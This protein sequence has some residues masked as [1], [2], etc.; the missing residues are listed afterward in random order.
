MS[1]MPTHVH[2]IGIGGINMSAIAKLLFR[3]GVKVS[4]SDVVASEQTEE[5]VRKGIP[6]IIGH[7]QAFVPEDAT[8]IIYSSAVPESDPERR[9]ARARG[10]RELTN[11]EFLAQWAQDQRVVLVTGTHGKS[12]TTALAG[13]MLIEGGLDPLVIV[14]SKVP[15][16]TD[17]NVRSGGGSIWLIEG[18]E[19]ARHFL[20]FQPQAILINNIELDHTDIFPTLDHMVGAFRELLHQVRDGGLVVANA[21][22]RNVSTLLGGERTALEARGVKIVTYGYGAH[23]MVRVSDEAIRVGE[24]LFLI[25]DERGQMIR[26]SLHVPGRMNICNATGAAALALALGAGTEPIRRAVNAFTGIWRRFETISDK[27]GVLV[28]SDYGHHPTAIRST[29]EAAR[30]FYPGRRI[31]LCFQPHQHNRTRQ[32]FLDFVPSFDLADALVLVEIYDVPGRKTHED[33]QVSSKDLCDA[34]RHHDAD[35][36]SQRPLEYAATVHEASP[37]IERWKRKGDIVIVMGAGDVYK[38]AEKL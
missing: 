22:D 18:D 13:L 16:F 23:A 26:G 27:D 1:E 25:K 8:L 14:G 31:V 15:A 20:A 33:E 21:D 4:G 12:T 32:L 28:I 6:V 2:L 30:S 10:L 36:L 9:Q 38:I 3:S 29:L 11:F 17:G 5:L 24:Q 37:I 35:R 34:I 7:E 19:Y